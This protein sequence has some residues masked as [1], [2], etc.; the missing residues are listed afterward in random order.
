[1]I[2]LRK[3][4]ETTS[5]ITLE[6]DAVPGAVGYRF[7]SSTTAPKWSH[8]FDPTRTEIKFSKA[9]SYKVEALG[10]KDAG[11]YP[12]VTPPEPPTGGTRI[13]ANGV[14]S[15]GGVWYGDPFTGTVTIQ[16]SSPVTLTGRIQNL[17]A[18]ALINAA[19]G[20]AVQLI[21][22]HLFALGG[23]SYQT[24]GRFLEARNYKSV[25]IRNC[26]IENTRGIELVW[27]IAGSLVLITKNKQKNIQGLGKSPVGNFVQFRE[28]QNAAIEVSW[29]EIVNEYNKSNPEDV[30][31]LYKSAHARI[32]S[33]G[34][35]HN[36][37]PGNAYNTSSQGTVTVEYDDQQGPAPTDNQIWDNYFIDTVNAV[38]FGPGVR[39]SIA[40]HNRLIQDGKLPNGTQMGNGYSGW[41]LHAGAVN[42]H[43]HQNV[44]G[45][46]G[47]D[48]GR[49]DWHDN[50]PGAPE[51]GSVEVSKNTTLPNPITRQT[52]LDYWA[53]WQAKVAAAGITIGA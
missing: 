24:S 48:G 6:W 25:T 5:T 34:I 14:I 49:T 47:R 7:Q 45:F 38:Y 33:N 3:K 39:D 35:N 30:I 9:A 28:V 41:A 23:D 8:T 4:S 42:C 26:T 36:S 19:P 12:T 46:V 51:G 16:T 32:H 29:N 13:P 10:V 18:G 43:M 40:H 17:S 52:E 31:S 22:D 27:G 1:M 11:V 21:L 53:E 37:T 50:L 2:T 15:S 44:S 20:G